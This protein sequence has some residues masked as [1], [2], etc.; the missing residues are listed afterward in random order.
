MQTYTIIIDEDQRVRLVEALRAAEV[1]IPAGE[2]SL[3]LEMLTDLPKV[4][5]E[6]PGVL[7]GLCL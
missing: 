3:L 7:H 5:K 6:N 4:E 2:H 1:G